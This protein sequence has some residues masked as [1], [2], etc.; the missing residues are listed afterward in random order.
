MHAIAV[1]NDRVHAEAAAAGIPLARVLVIADARHHLPRVAA[2]LA[3]EKRGGLDT[4]PQLFLPRTWL[5]RP[6][7][8]QRA[9]IVFRERRSRLGFLEALAHVGRLEHLH[10]EERVAARC[11][12]R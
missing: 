8:D 12:Q 3:A 7:V 9:S 11:V 10:P 1:A 6:D 5:D 2:V 4:G